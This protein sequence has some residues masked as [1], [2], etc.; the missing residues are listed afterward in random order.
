EILT[1]LGIRE[2]FDAVV[3]G[4]A[5][6][7]KK[8]DGEHLRHALAMMGD[9]PENVAI[10]VMVG[11]HANDVNAARDAGIAAIA[12]ALDVDETYARSLGADALVTEFRALPAAL[13]G[14]ASD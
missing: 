9:R 1:R 12:V 4:D 5:I 8:P 13:A 7:V 14:L 11:D 3:G 6:N 10:R 2:R